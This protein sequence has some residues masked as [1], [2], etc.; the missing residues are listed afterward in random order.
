MASRAF[1]SLVTVAQ[2]PATPAREPAR[3]EHEPT[4]PIRI[5][6]PSI[7]VPADARLRSCLVGDYGAYDEP[8]LPRA[9][10]M[11][12]PANLMTPLGV[13]VNSSPSRPPALVNGP[14][15]TYTRAEGPCTGGI[16]APLAPLGAYKLLGPAVSEIG[17]TIADLEDVVGADA[18]RLSE[19][20]QSARTWDERGR[21]LDGFLLDRAAQG[22]Q[23]SP[24]VT[25]AWHLLARSRGGHP[26]SEIARQVGW[27]HKHLITKFKQQIGVAPQLAARLLRL[28]VV[29]RHIDDDQSWARIAAESGYADQ[30]H[31]TREFR[32]FTGTTPAAL[33][34][35]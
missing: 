24:E 4:P 29:W 27:S 28:M 15:G 30:A 8:F 14:S 26:V 20:V 32:R 11:L 33:V 34:T 6:E 19:R 3:T 18:R 1:R 7:L 35:A 22:P 16:M 21:V 10:T 9:P 2:T 25:R 23:P 17:G 13:Y 12:L 5:F 31:L